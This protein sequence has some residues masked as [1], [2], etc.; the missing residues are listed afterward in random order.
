MANSIFFFFSKRFSDKK[1]YLNFK[2]F[3]SKFKFVLIPFLRLF[4]KIAKNISLSS[5][6]IEFNNLSK[7]SVF[8]DGYNIFT[9]LKNN[10]GKVLRKID[11]VY[12][13]LTKIKSANP[14]VKHSNL[15]KKK[16]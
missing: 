12:L 10:E 9:D 15:S 1:T 6:V 5:F 13:L 4:F 7:Y 8:N 16:R 14:V 3:S 11:S 2:K